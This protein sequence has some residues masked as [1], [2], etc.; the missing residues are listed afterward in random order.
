MQDESTVN[1]SDALPHPAVRLTHGNTPAPPPPI[2]RMMKVREGSDAT[3]C[4]NRATKE[5]EQ[6]CIGEG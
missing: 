5:L 3:S 2:G 4:P 6:D 1:T